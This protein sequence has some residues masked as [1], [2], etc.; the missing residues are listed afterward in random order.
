MARENT[1][2]LIVS[3]IHAPFHDEDAV[4]A[5]LEYAR[6]YKPGYVF[7]NGDIADFYSVS[8]YEKT[9][10]SLT[11]QEELDATADI[12][13]RFRKVAPSA[14]FEYLDGNHEAR[15]QLKLRKEAPEMQSLR[16]LDMRRL[17]ELDKLDFAAHHKYCEVREHFGVAIVH[18]DKV[19][20]KAGYAATG[21]MEKLGMS[22]VHGHTHRL[23]HVHKTTH[24]REFVG[25][26]G[27]CLCDMSPEYIAGTAN[28]QHGFVT[29]EVISGRFEPRI[30]RIKNGE[31]MP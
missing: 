4:S 6:D 19:S 23:A 13:R 9:N 1:R 24:G 17:L 28:W 5:V 15:L 31:V 12:L 16:C 21:L 3:D 18:G 2:T 25:I 29:G 20:G 26:E 11:L 7:F 22:V 14:R 27:G 10:R 8:R 30:H